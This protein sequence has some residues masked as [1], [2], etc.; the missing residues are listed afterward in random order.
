VGLVKAEHQ[1]GPVQVAHFGQILEQ[2][3]KKPQQ[4]TRVQPGL[5][6]QL[7]GRENV[8]DAATGQ[9]GSQQIGE[10]QCGLPEERMP[11]F[12][13]QGEQPALNRADRRRADEPVAGRNLLPVIGNERQVRT[14]V[15]KIEQE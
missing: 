11:T 14:Q 1:L 4:E 12:A 7:V 5:A 3:G 2:L 10:I 6:D 9:V 8:D 13:L 15:V